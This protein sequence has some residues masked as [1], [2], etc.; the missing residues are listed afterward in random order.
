MDKLDNETNFSS[1]R[2]TNIVPEISHKSKNV[3]KFQYR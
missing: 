3:A 1:S 2:N